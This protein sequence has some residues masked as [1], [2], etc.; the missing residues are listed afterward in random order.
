VADTG[1]F[2]LHLPTR[3]GG[4]GW[5]MADAAAAFEG[6]AAGC[7]DIGFLVAIVSH[8]GLVQSVLQTFGTEQQQ[9]HWL[10]GLI[11]G[12]LIGC[13]AITEQSGGSDVRAMKLAAHPDNAGGWRLEG[14]K[15]SVTNAS[16]A[17]LGITF[18]R[19]QHRAG[20]PVTA[21]LA[22]LRRPGVTASPPFDL[23][24]N[25]TTPVGELVFRDYPVSTDEVIGEA[26]RGLRVLDFAFVLERILTGI[27]I[28]GCLDS[29]IDCCLAR[30]E[31]RKAFGRAIG[32]NQYIQGHIVEMYADRELVRSAAWRALDSL[33]REQDCAALAS[34]V[35]MTAAEAFHRATLG[36]LRIHGNHGYR[37]GSTIE[38]LCRDAPGLL[39]AGGT[40]EIHKTIIWRNLQRG[41][42]CRSATAD[43]PLPGA[44][45]AHA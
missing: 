13:F 45:P 8:M 12:S 25:R 31:E 32:D 41:K 4:K 19:L 2:G 7:E 14:A 34:V 24:G 3:F 42:G 15:W 39:L 37:R 28:A 43:A 38:R 40:S 10:P 29:L 23:M 27:G 35:K 44:R 21:F 6:F 17:D 5:S 33:V 9:R 20:K 16:A 30:A 26:G 1:L 11:D 22:D 18:A 36:A